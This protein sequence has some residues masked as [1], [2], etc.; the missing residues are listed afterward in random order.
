MQCALSANNQGLCSE[1]GTMNRD[2]IEIRAVRAIRV[3]ANGRVGRL[4]IYGLSYRDDQRIRVEACVADI[5]ERDPFPDQGASA[6]ARMVDPDR[7]SLR[8]GKDVFPKVLFQPDAQGRRAYAWF[9][10]IDLLLSPALPPVMIGRQA[11]PLVVRAFYVYQSEALALERVVELAPITEFHTGV[12]L[13]HGIGVQRRAETLSAWSAPLL[14]WINAW[15]DGGA[16][17]IADKLKKA[18]VEGWR[19]SLVSFDEAS[20]MDP[21][22][23]HLDRNRYARALADKVTAERQRKAKRPEECTMRDKPLFDEA[24]P[25]PDELAERDTVISAIANMGASAVGGS[26]EFREAYVLDVGSHASDPSS[27]EMHVEAMAA[28]GYILRSRWM[29][30]ES[31]WAESFWA[32]SFFRF[33]RWCLLIA[34]IVL[35]HYVALAQV[36]YPSLFRRIVVTMGL[37]IGVTIAQVAFVALMVL[38]I[39]PWER[40]RS[41]VLRIQMAI[42]GIV[43]DSYILLE[44]PVQRRAIIDRV[45]RD[46]N[47]LTHRCRNVVVVAHSQGAAVAELVLSGQEEEG[48]G[49]IESFI[50]LGA[51][52]QTLNAILKYARNRA[53]NL[54]GWLAI[55]STLLLGAAVVVALAYAWQLG[56]LIAAGAFGLQWYAVRRGVKA[57]GGPPGRI[58]R[59]AR[60]RPWFD[61]FATKDLVPYGPAIA[62]KHFGGEYLYKEVRNRDSFLSDHVTYWQNAEQ[63]VS[64]LV[65]QFGEV[66]GFPPLDRLLPD[67]E[68]T[69]D[70]LERARESRLGFLR[71]ARLVTLLATALLLY[72]QWSAFSE[73]FKWAWEWLQSKFGIAAAG[74]MPALSTWL[75]ALLVLLPL[76]IHKSLIA[77]IFDAWTTA[78]VEQLLR[79]AAGSPATHWTALFTILLVVMLATPLYLILTVEFTVMLAATALTAFALAWLARRIHAH[80]ARLMP[81]DTA[82]SVATA[83]G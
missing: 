67:D 6:I 2:R 52:V 75:R 73:I 65:H 22:S 5:V 71:T 62:A 36:R 82:T 53:V 10:E 16:Y 83:P 45:Q 48:K 38:W 11:V 15:F 78:E 55:G 21:A 46:L 54:A 19:D 79:R 69:L 56:A 68:A 81:T 63:V 40:L 28:D 77:S 25:T 66:A 57:H 24:P 61:F 30:A 42:S 43:G 7:S 34:P 39:V 49:K 35:I 59:A 72:T 37:S 8:V 9:V 50:T 64:R 20:L 58:P 29:L 3:D 32:P 17:A 26:A 60:Y 33:A 12:L 76:A 27:V 70:R 31:H 13:V 18:P 51:G 80:R 14:R 1:A 44:D 74:E 4:A 47:W 41:S 23:D